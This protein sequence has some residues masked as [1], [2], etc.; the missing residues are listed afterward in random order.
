MK[1]LK[2]IQASQAPVHQFNNLQKKLYN[3][4]TN[5]YFNREYLKYM[6]CLQTN[7]MHKFINRLW[8][9]SASMSG[10][11]HTLYVCVG[12]VSLIV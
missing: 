3:C 12:G 6:N 11:L 7:Y 5:I 10:H 9:V 2:I 8:R 4:N 1:W